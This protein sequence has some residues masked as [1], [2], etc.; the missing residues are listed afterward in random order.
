[1]VFGG[2]LQEIHTD[3]QVR[4]KG[5]LTELLILQGNKAAFYHKVE[6]FSLDR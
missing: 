1:M 5:T 3:N 2:K 4:G 6:Y